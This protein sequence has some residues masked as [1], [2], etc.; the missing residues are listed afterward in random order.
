MAGTVHLPL[1]GETNKATLV[2]AGVAG[3]A[4]LGWALW[5]D[6]KSKATASTAAGTTSTGAPGVTTTGYGYSY[7]PYGYGFGSSGLGEYG[8]DNT[9][10]YGE[11]YYGAG[12]PVN[13][14][15]PGQASTNAQWSEASMTALTAAGWSGADVLTALG[16]Y[17]TGSPV[18]AT[19]TGIIQAAIAA[20]GYPPAPGA[21]GYPPAIHTA[22]STGQSGTGTVKAPNV[23]GQPQEA[24]FAIIGASGLKASGSKTVKGK[25]L[26]VKSQSP[27]A[28]ASVA[29]GSTVTLTSSTAK[30]K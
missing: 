10:D 25:T 20:E 27:S 6:K 26:Y 21:N 8:S 1:V 23:V 2:I 13:E 30:P 24:A 4:A 28:G 18:S 29:K 3:T 17:L 11:G 5:K 7:Q 22:P 14:E 9:G 12:V 16:L 19:Q 15:V